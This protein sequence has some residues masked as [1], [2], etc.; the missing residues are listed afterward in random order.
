MLLDDIKD[1]CKSDDISLVYCSNDFSRGTYRIKDSIMNEC[2]LLSVDLVKYLMN[3]RFKEFQSKDVC[4]ITE[5]RKLGYN[6]DTIVVIVD[7]VLNNT[8]NP[9][10]MK[11]IDLVLRLGRAVGFKIISLS[12]FTNE[13]S[14]FTFCLDLE[15][16]EGKGL[17]IKPEEL[18]EDYI[19]KNR[20]TI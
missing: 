7:D 2:S 12:P 11:N 20:D 10:D 4:N 8:K 14:A 6:M 18:L 9:R 16:E 3:K 17:V 5:Y 13:R 15:Y 19:S 1:K